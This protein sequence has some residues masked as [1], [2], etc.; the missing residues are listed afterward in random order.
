MYKLEFDRMGQ[1]K[2][3]AKGRA[4]GDLSLRIKENTFSSERTEERELV[5]PLAI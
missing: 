3:Q 5:K 4:V 1:L 2:R